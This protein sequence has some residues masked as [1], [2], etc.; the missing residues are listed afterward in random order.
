M[1][2]WAVLL[3]GAIVVYYMFGTSWLRKKR[4][5]SKKKSVVVPI[6][7][8]PNPAPRQS[9]VTCL[10]CS[11]DTA[12]CRCSS[13]CHLCDNTGFNHNECGVCNCPAGQQLRTGTVS[14]MIGQN[15]Q[16]CGQNQIDCRCG[17]KCPKCRNTGTF[18]GFP[19][20]T[21][22][23]IV[24]ANSPQPV[25]TPQFNLVPCSFCG[26]PVATCPCTDPRKW[27]LAGQMPSC[28]RCSQPSINCRCGPVC[29]H[30]SGTGVTPYG[31]QCLCG[32][33]S[34]GAG[35]QIVTE[36]CHVCGRSEPSNVLNGGRCSCGAKRQNRQ[37]GPASNCPGCGEYWERCRCATRIF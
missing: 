7:Q 23:V 3:C 37:V 32:S 12:I 35:F 19:C 28:P 14:K 25:V 4:S 13:K 17:V 20:C 33:I 29:G 31:S 1:R 5:L 18:M 22:D 6:V 16:L 2:L 24:S 21:R 27:M 26:G 9:G 11:L 34:T 10:I 15:C 36:M 30:C 8:L